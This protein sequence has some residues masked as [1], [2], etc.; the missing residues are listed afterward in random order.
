MIIDAKTSK[1]S[2]EQKYDDTFLSPALDT[3]NCLIMIDALDEWTHPT[4]STCYN[5]ER[6]S[7]PPVIV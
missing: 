3:E 6:I 5:D 7:H 1:T 4:N 2:F